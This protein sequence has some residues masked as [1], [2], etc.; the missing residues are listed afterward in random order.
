VHVLYGTY[1]NQKGERAPADLFALLHTAGSA[2][3]HLESRLGAIGLS[4]A[5][6]AALRA[7]SEA[8]ES[9][10]LGQLAARLSCVKSNITQLVDRL[11]GDG[12]VERKPDPHDRR[13]RLAV[14]T[15]AGRKACRNGVRVQAEAERDLFGG[16]TADEARQLGAL[17]RKVT[18]PS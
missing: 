1:V 5:K 16:L 9:L 7:L 10:P 13:G 4:L 6:L 18:P 2:E 11:E 14:M 12:L 15:A 3:A 17:M 8:G